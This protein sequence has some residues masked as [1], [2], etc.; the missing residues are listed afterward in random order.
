MKNVIAKVREKLELYNKAYISKEFITKI[1][2]KFAPNYSISQLCNMW[3]LTPIK[4]GKWYVNN[5][6][7]EYINPFVV[8]DLYM[9]N[10]LYMFGWIMMYNRYNISDQVPEWYTIYNTK[11]SWKKI[12]WSAKFIFIRQREN[13]FYGMKNEKFEE[14]NYKVMTPERAFIQALKEKKIF[15]I[16]PYWIDKIKL[17]KLAKK[18]ASQTI[19]DK[20]KKLCL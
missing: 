17:I 1:L 19:N 11:I 5:K 12:I 6:T 3:L 4:R 8:G 16:V 15:D 14:Y 10:E 2:N 18:N 20:I 7:R 9:W 13:F